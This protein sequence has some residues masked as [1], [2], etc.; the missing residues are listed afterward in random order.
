MLRVGA[1]AMVRVAAIVWI[2][3]CVGLFFSKTALQ[4]LVCKFFKGTS[5]GSVSVCVPVYLFEVLLPKYRGMGIGALGLGAFAG[6]GIVVALGYILLL[7]FSPDLAFHYTW[8]GEAGLGGVVLL[9]SF[10]LPELP[11]SLTRR[12]RWSKAANVLKKL[13][14]G[15]DGLKISEERAFPL[16]F[17]EM[18]TSRIVGCVT[19]GVF[20]QITSQIASVC[21]NGSFLRYLNALCGF[22]DTAATG[23][24]IAQYALLV[25][26][27]SS[28]VYFLKRARRKDFLVIGYL[29]LGATYGALAGIAGS[30]QTP[31][32]A[33]VTFG[34]E[35]AV[36]DLAGAWLMAVSGISV[37]FTSLLIPSAALLYTLEVLPHNARAYGLSIA[38]FASWSSSAAI[39]GTMLLTSRSNP[40]ILFMVLFGISLVVMLILLLFPET[41]EKVQ[42]EGIPYDLPRLLDNKV[43]PFETSLAPT[44]LSGNV[45]TPQS[46]LQ[47]VPSVKSI[48]RK[49]SLRRLS[50]DKPPGKVSIDS[51]ASTPL[52][53][54]NSHLPLNASAS[55]NALRFPSSTWL[56]PISF[57]K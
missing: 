17:S 20:V 48:P 4:H 36:R 8:L 13:S 7:S 39:E 32:A 47:T 50:V 41:V 28:P 12:D 11:A 51:G 16:R 37:V 42:Y 35:Y 30:Y 57:L 23:F 34:P 1:L 25:V 46:A 31:A 45:Q 56:E 44:A 53:T 33:T 14:R 40:F 3:A 22:N 15:N 2:I 21:Y 43:S 19:V 55:R 6:Q 5:M 54:A 10:F 27:G 9:C 38:L 18:C 26:V 49:T 24:V 29:V 52:Y